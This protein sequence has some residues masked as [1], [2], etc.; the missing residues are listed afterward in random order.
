MNRTLNRL[1]I[2]PF[3]AVVVTVIFM[4]G[5][6]SATQLPATDEAASPESTAT[7][8]EVPEGPAPTEPEPTEPQ[9]TEP[10]PTEPPP[11]QPPPTETTSPEEPETPALPP[12]P[13]E[14]MTIEFEAADGQQL[15]GTYYPAAVNPAPGVVL[16]H[17]APGDQCDW[18]AVAPWL[19]NRGVKVECAAAQEGPWLD[20][21]WFPPL[22]EG[23]SYAVFTFTFRGCEGGCANFQ[24]D[25]WLLDAKA[26]METIVRLPGVDTTRL[27]AIGASI[28]A[29]GALNG[30][31]NGCLGALSLSPGSYLGLPYSEE[32]DRLG[33][34]EPPV[35][36]VCLAAEDDGDSAETCSAASG[37]LYGVIIYPGNDH[38]VQLINPDSEPNVLKVILDFLQRTLG[39]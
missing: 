3:V 30:C 13:A 1:L 29:D 2:I 18:R 31:E 25:G 35:P 9:P 17:W 11:T 20:S 12:I 37:D 6:A 22:A 32:V 19:Q 16:F 36:V 34:G 4:A 33:S 8:T 39:S 15:V 14:P 38:G 7:P 23:E 28:G 26:A 27:A 5:C 21:S 24:P 10:P